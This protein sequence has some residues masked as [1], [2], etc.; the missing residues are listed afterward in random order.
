MR[1]NLVEKN[2]KGTYT[3]DVYH[4]QDKVISGKISAAE[5]VLGQ[6]LY[7]KYNIEHDGYCPEGFPLGSGDDID[8]IFCA[9]CGMIQDFKNHTD[10]WVEAYAGS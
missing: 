2:L 4:E 5:T 3:D 8:F 6:T 10:D 9:E 7:D 1:Q